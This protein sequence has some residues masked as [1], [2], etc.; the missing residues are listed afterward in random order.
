MKNMKQYANNKGQVVGTLKD[1][2]F[3]KEVHSKKHKMRNFACYGIDTRIIKELI[4]ENCVEVRI[5][6]T[7]TGHIYSSPF[8]AWVSYGFEKDY[9]DGRQTFLPMKYYQPVKQP[10]LL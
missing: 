4:Q 10:T 1:G 7:D 6:E 9:G 5:R 2:I 3:R 8:S